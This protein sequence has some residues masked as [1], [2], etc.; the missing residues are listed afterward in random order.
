MGVP[1]LK[2]A[3]DAG[4]ELD[5]YLASFL[6]RIQRERID[7][8]GAP[9]FEATE[10][11]LEAAVLLV[12]LAG[13]TAL[14]R[15]FADR[16]A[17]GAEA[18]SELITDYF[19]RTG[20]VVVEHGGEPLFF[21]GDSVISIFR[22]DGELGD[23]TRRAA[24]A[25]AAIH[26]LPIEGAEDPIAQLRYAAVTAG[27]IRIM[28][29]GG[30]DDRWAPLVVGDAIGQLAGAIR[31]AGRGE[32][33][34]SAKALEA[35]G[36]DVSADPLEGGFA[37]LKTLAPVEPA[38][39]TPA[40]SPPAPLLRPYV[41]DVVAEIA[42]SDAA[43][44]L[45]EFRSVTIAF[46]NL[47][48][49]GAGG[50]GEL[51]EV[52]RAVRIAQ[53][54]L[55]HFEGALHQIVMDEKGV[56]LLL[57]F[58]LPPLA[59]EYDAERA[60]R[61]AGAIREDLTAAGLKSAIGVATGQM[62]TGVCGG[63]ALRHFAV[64]GPAINLAA[65][66]MQTA[67]EDGVLFDDATRR[68]AGDR[69]QSRREADVVAKGFD[70]PVVVHRLSHSKEPAAPKTAPKSASHL[71]GRRGERARIDALLESAADGRGGVALVTGEAGMGKSLL[72]SDVEAEAKAAGLRVFSGAGDAIETGARLFAWRP[73][74]NDVLSGANAQNADADPDADA[75][76]GDRLTR[77]LAGRKT[78]LDWAPLL[79]DILPL[80][81]PA[82]DLT[83]QMDG[84]ARDE[85]AREVILALIEA[86]AAQTPLVLVIDDAHWCD[87]A[88][89]SLIAAVALRSP[90][91]LL[92][93]GAR[94]EFADAPESFRRL[95]ERPDT[96]A[97][98]LSGLNEDATRRIAA[99]RLGVED[100]PDAF[101]SFI[102]TRAEGNPFYTEELSLSLAESG[103]VTVAGGQLDTSDFDPAA[104][105]AAVPTS[106]QGVVTSRIDR[107]PSAA[108]IALKT[109]SVIGRSFGREMLEALFPS[110]ANAE[111]EPQLQILTR[112]A[113]IVAMAD[114]RDVAARVV[115]DRSAY[116]ANDYIFRHIITRDAAYGLMLISQRRELHRIAAEWIA[117]RTDAEDAKPWGLLAYH[118]DRANVG[119]EAL[120]C[121][122]KAGAEAL[123]GF[124]NR[125]AIT[126]YARA[127]ELM[128]ET[129]APE[130]R[131]RARMH[132]A[133]ARAYHNQTDFTAAREHYEIALA[134]FGA[135]P[136][137]GNFG[138]L[139]DL[140]RGVAGQ[141][142]RRWRPEAPTR[143]DPEELEVITTTRLWQETALFMGD[144]LTSLAGIFSYL[145]RAERIG[146]TDMRVHGYSHLAIMLN[147]LGFR[148]AAARYNRFT[149]E[150]AGRDDVNLYD[151]SYAWVATGVYLASVGAWDRLPEA[152]EHVDDGFNRLGDRMRWGTGFIIEAYTAISLDDLE[153]ADATFQ[154]AYD[155][156]Y[157]D[158]AEQIMVWAAGGQAIARLKAG[159]P[160]AKLAKELLR[161]AEA[162]INETE[163]LLAY[164]AAAGTYAALGEYAAGRDAAERAVEAMKSGTHVFYYLRLPAATTAEVL[165]DAYAQGDAD[166]L[167]LAKVAVKT[168]KQ[169]GFMNQIAKPAALL[170]DGKL[171]L[172]LG[173]R[174]RALKLFRKSAEAAERLQMPGDRRA[175]EEAMAALST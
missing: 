66:L 152:L 128:D 29:V 117:A 65:R 68:A 109:S 173:K 41:P 59:H 163:D 90:R 169:I 130:G 71:I 24:A 172:A 52:Q 165:L 60:L 46:V 143:H 5:R 12:D 43:R 27:D 164:G 7:A 87:S 108:Q 118:Y 18:L 76:L 36:S 44:W 83:R 139:R 126:F 53:A 96:E 26:R 146:A 121:Y 162:G 125:E 30:H 25:A 129:G 141:I 31:A 35:L 106:L 51:A 98:P 174:S 79:N 73:I 138:A 155:S 39:P 57:G 119:E 124:A 137:T 80:N 93:I 170:L 166:A 135:S 11:A 74:L 114:S 153:H 95:I 34:C 133:L 107:L 62:F 161:R 77:M 145:N 6:P 49:L 151:R 92:V 69:I 111:L 110:D 2:H 103:A 104:A 115:G 116:E 159:K 102:S 84:G 100:V 14:A 127:L 82:T 47:P 16:G 28:E 158:G 97:L 150:L 89:L 142:S 122:E 101:A 81:L 64:I 4:P 132:A 21:G 175:A 67:G 8:R 22:A 157:P 113:L 45:A 105:S 72:L 91:T 140:L 70:R 3:R 131:R 160:D 144:A 37:R 40:P 13:F 112:Q 15:R 42:T 120:A 20:D 171:A 55:A 17:E 94:P 54:H 99:R 48:A 23:A 136:P 147:V 149:L 1:V 85:S 123:E 134:G 148:G 167:P 63:D 78:L 154:K 9:A 86:A 61:A 19:G 10:T 56:S 33:I 156:A 88:S 50:E 75:T 38:P 168:L 32:I 58:G